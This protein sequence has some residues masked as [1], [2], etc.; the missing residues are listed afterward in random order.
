MLNY[1]K[2]NDK[3]NNIFEKI[4][5]LHLI[6]RKKKVKEAL[7]NQNLN[8]ERLKILLLCDNTNEDLIY[9]YILSLDEKQS[10][11]EILK[12]SN[13]LS[14]KKIE[15]LRLNIPSK[16]DLFFRKI[17]F[18]VLFF[19]FLFSLENLDES[20]LD[21]QIGV[22]NAS[23]K[24]R[25]I[26]N[27][28]Y[29]IDNLEALYYYFCVLF[30][31]QI[32]ANK[33]KKVKYFDYLKLLISKLNIL[34]EYYKEYEDNKKEVTYEKEIEDFNKFFTIIFAI[35]NLD[36]NNYKEISRI[37][38]VL[39]TPNIDQKKQM[40]Y[41]AK[42]EIKNQYNEKMANE[43]IEKVKNEDNYFSLKY[44]IIDDKIE[45]LEESYLYDYIM[46]NNIYKKYEKQILELLNV[47][48]KSGLIKHL[49]KAI[50]IKDDKTKNLLFF[51]D[52][53]ESV[54]YLWKKIILFVPFK[55]EKISGFSYKEFFKIFISVYKIK[56][57]NTNLEDE[58][59]T[60]GAFVRT[61]IHET[62]G[63]FMIAYIFF[64]FYANMEDI[65]KY[66]FPRMEN[67]VKELNKE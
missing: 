11:S 37:A 26:N 6:E 40:I 32:E 55:I 64:M 35:V 44:S 18:K 13:Y 61:L 39:N 36:F 24:Q 31:K 62:F 16:F 66:D 46:E 21:Y 3:I 63:R 8:L 67:Q 27:Q 41:C 17:P 10:F 38:L 50:Y 7:K 53:E 19:N 60:L 12:Y 43:F 33:I 51:F 30:S 47:I 45:L 34:K 29:D 2:K 49:F 25:V 56:H 59:F 9:K 20:A 58:I 1:V 15:Q 52:I 22:L 14:T 57:F 5:K 42:E 23:I 48:Y 4:V 65:K 28:P 54:E